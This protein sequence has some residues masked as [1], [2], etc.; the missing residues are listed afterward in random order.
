M[1]DKIKLK[2]LKRELEERGITEPKRKDVM[3]ILEVSYPQAY[4]YLKA[5]REGTED[6]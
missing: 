3:E 2:Y 5:L 4:N 1:I 6:E